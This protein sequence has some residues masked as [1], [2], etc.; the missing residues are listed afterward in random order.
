MS[1]FYDDPLLQSVMR[2]HQ[3]SEWQAVNGLLSGLKKGRALDI[4][5]GRGIATYALAKD[6]WRVTALEPDPSPI[7]G[8][9]AIREVARS[10]NGDIDVVEEFAEK[11]PFNDNRFDL[12][13]GRAIMH[14]AKDLDGF[15]RE[16]HRVLKPD[17]VFLFTR[18]HVVN[19]KREL[20]L[21]L[22]AHPLHAIYQGEYAYPLKQYERALKR[23]GL[24]I[25]KTIFP[26]DSDINLF[27][28][29][30]VEFR[31]KISAKLK[32]KI[33]NKIF[34]H[35]IIPILNFRNRSPGRL[36]SFIGSKP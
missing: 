6:G 30:H 29:N 18:E 16:V 4:G 3:S 33:P 35:L 20:Q 31:E 22:D 34:Y 23:A 19:N 27:P 11:I 14:H 5:A 17:G 36:F 8:A 24:I 25:R 12:V 26:Y 13:Y 28:S 21:F 2:Y 15:C 9:E 1:C 10:G 32:I 7:V